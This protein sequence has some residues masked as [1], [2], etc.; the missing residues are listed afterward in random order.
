MRPAGFEPA[1]KGF[2]GP[3]VSTRLGLSHPP[4]RSRRETVSEQVLSR[5]G[6]EPEEEAGRSW[7][8]LLL[9]LT[10][11]VSEPSWP[12]EPG[13]AWLRIAVPKSMPRRCAAAPIGHTTNPPCQ[14]SPV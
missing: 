8:G 1:T 6:S 5:S 12:P 3:R 10:P 2:K 9:G 11:L 14:N 7:R 13:Q 4:I